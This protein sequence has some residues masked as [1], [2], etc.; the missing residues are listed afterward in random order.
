MFDPL[1]GLEQVDG[2]FV[3]DFDVDED[4]VISVIETEHVDRAR[5]RD[6]FALIVPEEELE[7]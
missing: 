7:Y 1:E 6:G 4:T 5:I 2:I 3:D